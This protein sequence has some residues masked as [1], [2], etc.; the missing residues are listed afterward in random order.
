MTATTGAVT[1]QGTSQGTATCAAGDKVIGGG[2]EAAN[3]NW[4][5]GASY[6]AT[7]TDNPQA[8]I[9]VANRLPGNNNQQASTVYALCVTP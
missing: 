7:T 4:V 6:P 9:G 5:V 8:W 3:N 1:P 2:V